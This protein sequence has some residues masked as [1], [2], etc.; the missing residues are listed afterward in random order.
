MSILDCI[1]QAKAIHRLQRARQSARVPHGYIFFGPEGVGKGLLARQ[2]AKLLL[3]GQPVRRSLSRTDSVSQS[4]LSENV[5]DPSASSGQ[6]LRVGMP[7]DE[8]H[9]HAGNARDRN[10]VGMAP[11]AP[12]RSE[13]TP[14]LRLAV[15]PGTASGGEMEDCCDEYGGLL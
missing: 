5:P 1:G 2:W 9:A 6:R 14:K 11:D 10:C 15:P 7:P 3:C 4:L 8:N 13:A 12:Y